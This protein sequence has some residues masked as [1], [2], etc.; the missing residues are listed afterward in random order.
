MVLRET[1]NVRTDNDDNNDNDDDD[2]DDVDDDDDDDDAER[3]VTL[4]YELGDSRR[5]VS[6]AVVRIA[7]EHAS[8]ASLDF[9]DC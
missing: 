2:D 7:E 3:I 8:V 4:D 1:T 9:S 6:D 5:H